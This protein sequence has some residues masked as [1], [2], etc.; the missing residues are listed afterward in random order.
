MPDFVNQRVNKGKW[1]ADRRGY[2]LFSL[3]VRGL[4]FAGIEPCKAEPSYSDTE[5]WNLAVETRRREEYAAP[6]RL[7][8]TQYQLDETG[9]EKSREHGVWAISYAANGKAAVEVISATKDGQDFTEERKRRV[10][11]NRERTTQMMDIP[12]P[13]DSRVQSSLRLGSGVLAQVEGKAVYAYPFELPKEDRT[14]AGTAWVD[15]RKGLPIGFQYTMKPLP[16]LVDK[17]EVRVSFEQ[18]AHPGRFKE[19]AYVFAASFLV[20]NWIGGGTAWPEDWV[21]L[22][23]PPRFGK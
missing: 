8:Y 7:R 17:I 1:I 20:F 13:F 15:A 18:D 9:A 4:V 6:R 10:S 23:V 19:V 2:L 22:P 14:L 11:R 5:A 12:S 3:A 16:M 21:E